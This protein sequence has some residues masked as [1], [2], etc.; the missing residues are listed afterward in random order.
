[1]PSPPSFGTLSCV[2][3]TGCS[4]S[5]HPLLSCFQIPGPSSPIALQG[6]RVPAQ[7]PLPTTRWQDESSV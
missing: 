3:P 7:L 2:V 4:G 5:P 1:M 6:G